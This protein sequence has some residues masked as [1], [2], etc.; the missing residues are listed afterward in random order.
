MNKTV[1]CAIMLNLLVVSFA[2]AGEVNGEMTPADGARGALAS[3]ARSRVPRGDAGGGKPEPDAIAQTQG[4]YLLV[5]IAGDV[6][7][8]N[9]THFRTDLIVRNAA[10]GFQNVQIRFLPA[11]QANVVSPA[12][13]LL[14]ANMEARSTFVFEDVLT[15]W[16]ASS[17]FGALLIKITDDGD[18]GDNDPPALASVT[19]GNLTASC[20]IYTEQPGGNGTTSQSSDAIDLTHSQ[21]FSSGSTAGLRQDSDF[22][23]NVGIVNLDPALTRN[24]TVTMTSAEANR[25]PTRAIVMSVAVPPMSMVQRALPQVNLGNILLKVELARPVDPYDPLGANRGSQAAATPAFWTAYGS[26]VDN[27]TG[28][29]WLQMITPD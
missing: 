27:I 10:K 9:G 5:P 24:F 21:Y 23:T 16:L 1:Q 13:P 17:G 11:E 19:Q 6:Q 22:R 14:I 18:R 3:P 7:G 2:A 25:L 15:R 29:S 26:T 4:G 12:Y 8:I 28:D 20:R